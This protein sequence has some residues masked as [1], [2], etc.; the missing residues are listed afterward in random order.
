MA[1]LARP[2]HAMIGPGLRE[3]HQMCQNREQPGDSEKVSGGHCSWQL[4]HPLDDSG[5][6]PADAHGQVVGNLGKLVS[7]HH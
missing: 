3:G 7:K 1:E 5:G 2:S 6:V 4:Q